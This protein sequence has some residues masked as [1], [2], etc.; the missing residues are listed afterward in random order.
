MA[1]LAKQKEDLN[2]QL[3]DA[4]A[5]NRRLA[6]TENRLQIVSQECERVNSVLKGKTE[7]LA[8]A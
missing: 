1:S 8:R 6:E 4:N 5:V 7:E 3:L 2:R